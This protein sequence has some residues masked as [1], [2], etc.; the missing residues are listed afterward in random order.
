MFA[1]AFVVVSHSRVN[2]NQS[3]KVKPIHT[4]VNHVYQISC[5]N[6][7]NIHTHKANEIGKNN[8]VH[9][10][11]IHMCNRIKGLLTE[12]EVYTGMFL[13]E[14]IVQIVRRRSEVCA[15]NRRKIL[16]H[17]ERANEVYKTSIIWILV[18]FRLCL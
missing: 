16:S 7:S 17:T 6:G 8:R 2:N 13:P 4:D 12:C 9:S 3:E 18:H 10:E 11:S 15:K 5:D 14:V 1:H